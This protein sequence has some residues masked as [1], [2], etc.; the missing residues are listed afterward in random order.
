MDRC[1]ANCIYGRLICNKEKREEY[2]GCVQFRGF[3]REILLKELEDSRYVSPIPDIVF[4]GWIFFR[5]P[6]GSCRDDY[7]TV[8]AG[9]IANGCLISPKEAYCN[10]FVARYV[11]EANKN[12]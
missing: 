4:T 9:V 5:L 3:E 1:C 11:D 7:D 12:F 10:R 8:D 2:V 6:F